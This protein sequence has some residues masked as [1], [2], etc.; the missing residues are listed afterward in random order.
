[1]SK[2]R[3]LRYVS[4]ADMPESMQRLLKK[5]AGAPQPE[6]TQ[7]NAPPRH[8]RH[9]PGVMNKTEAAYAQHLDYRKAAGEVL[10]WGFEVV[11]L[12]LAKKTYLT[13]DFLV[14]LADCSFE[15]HEVKGRKGE[16]FW[17]EEDAMVKLKVAAQLTP[18]PVV[19][20]WPRKGGGWGEER[21]L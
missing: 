21:A 14:Q 16:R 10:W 15:F 8:R 12:R 3:A 2:R 18:I 4:V 19:V 6:Q 17:A 11:K 9:E 1:M 13:I 20:V 7:P 5:S